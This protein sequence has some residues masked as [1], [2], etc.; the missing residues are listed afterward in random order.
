[1]R[2]SH[3]SNRR[4]SSTRW[5][6]CIG[7]V[8]SQVQD[9]GAYA[10]LAHPERLLSA[11]LVLDAT[12]D[13]EGDRAR[14]A[15]EVAQR[16]ALG[17]R[18]ERSVTGLVQDAELLIAGS[19]RING[20]DE[21]PVLQLAA[22]L[23]TPDQAEALYALSL[24]GDEL[25]DRDRSRL[26]S[27][28]ELVQAALAHPELVGREATDAVEQ[29]RQDVARLVDDPDGRERLE[30]AP[31]A[32][33]LAVAPADLARRVVLCDPLPRPGTVRVTVASC[34]DSD[35]TMDV[36][37]RDRLGLLARLTGVLTADGLDVR[38][39][40]VAVWGDG[41][42]LASFDVRG[43]AKPDASRLQ[44]EITRALEQPL[45]CPPVSGITVEIDDVGSPWHSLAI[46]RGAD[47]PGLLH[48]VTTAFAAVGADVHAAHVQSDG[49][50]SR[51]SS[52]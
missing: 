4:R 20:L 51:I 18:G 41:C 10:E 19:R 21:E 27:L 29:R 46:V 14:V 33:L 42:V 13:A 45:S 49:D 25:D 7:R 9:D 32:Y 12:E 44:E 8:C 38:S 1:M 2:R 6:L 43:V 52:S 23:A 37:T 17:P 34:G 36:V 15:R 47:Q 11:A 16:L 48:A 28:Y 35:W 40:V 39:A 30:H 5:R 22:H 26:S 31:R 24:S 50:E 3:G